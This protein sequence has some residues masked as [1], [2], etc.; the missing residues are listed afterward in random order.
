MNLANTLR[1][2]NLNAGSAG[3]QATVPDSRSSD[4]WIKKFL[5][6]K[7]KRLN[8]LR[9]SLHKLLDY[10]EPIPQDDRGPLR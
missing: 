3:A 5:D 9:K 10:P 4:E 2:Q 7:N 8:D 1:L 6:A